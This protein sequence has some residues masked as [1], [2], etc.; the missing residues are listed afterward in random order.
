MVD[1]WCPYTCRKNP[2]DVEVELQEWAGTSGLVVGESARR[3]FAGARFGDCAAYVY[4][5]AP[6]L[7]VHAKWLAWLFVADDEFDENR[8][9]EHG[10]IDRGVLGYLPLDGPPTVTPTT[11]VTTA[12]VDLWRELAP[13]M[14]LP[15]RERFRANAERY[16]RT[17]GTDLARSRAGTA[18][19]LASYIA[20]RRSS[21][22]VDTCVDLVE[23]GPGAYL[24]RPSAL[25]DRVRTAA[26]DVICW[27][28]DVLSVAK[29][30]RHGE[31]TN[32]V[33]VLRGATGMG[34]STSTGIAAEMVSARTRE[35]DSLRREL[36]DSDDS[37]NV[38]R[39]VDG[40]ASWI[41]GSLEWHL[42]SPRYAESL[43]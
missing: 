18:P 22:A 26:N 37:P 10:G 21:G 5:D 31:L 16:A 2:V 8:A 41:A 13:P 30:V 34:W 11:A 32:L 19:D 9:P 27:S 28:N 1:L 3:K 14:P 20:L 38:R 33:A 24:A 36:L 42:T 39:F 23:R 12:L 17:Y 15:L 25:V 40:L 6:D 35:F 4:P 29:E 43:V 7:L